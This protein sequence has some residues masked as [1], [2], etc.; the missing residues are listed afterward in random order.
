MSGNVK[1]LITGSKGMLGSGFVEHFNNGIVKGYSRSNLDINNDQQISKV[2]ELEKPDIIIHTAAFTD[3]DGCEKNK[4]KAYLVNTVGTMNLV[5]Y[6]IDKNVLLVFISSTGIY[7]SANHSEQYNEFDFVN[8]AS[9]HHKSKYEAEKIIERHLNKFLIIRTGW[10]FG[11][12]KNHNKNFVYKRYLEAKSQ[13]EIYSDD[14]QIGNP[15]YTVDLVEQIKLL[16]NC[17]HY[18]T[19]NC[20]NKAKNISRFDYVKKIIELF[21]LSTNLKS[22]SSD[23]FDRVAPVSKNE[24]A[25]NYKLDLLGINIM[26][27]WELSLS[28]YIEKLKGDL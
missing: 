11:G 21:D 24:S 14:S 6:C 23:K 20:V 15:T 12:H 19:F 22:S 7:G 17:G 26:G 1:T 9:I 16:I 8:P 2:L 27:D 5:K 4:D 10:L 3:V 28:K 25:I 18:G 13:N